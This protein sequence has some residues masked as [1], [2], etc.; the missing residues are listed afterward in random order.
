MASSVTNNFAHAS[1]LGN[2]RLS[3]VELTVR[4]SK[5]GKRILAGQYGLGDTIGE[6]QLGKIRLGWRLPPQEQKSPS[7]YENRIVL[8]THVTPEPNTKVAVKIFNISKLRKMRNLHAVRAEIDCLSRLS[9]TNIIKLYEIIENPSKHR[10]YLVIELLEG[11]LNELIGTNPNGL[12]EEE[13][14]PLFYR[15]FSAV[16]HCHQNQVA[17]RDIKPDNVMFTSDGQVRLMDFSGGELD[18][19]SAPSISSAI[20]LLQQSTE[21]PSLLSEMCYWGSPAFLP[22]E[23]VDTVSPL[24]SSLQQGFSADSWAL[25][26]SLHITLTGRFPFPSTDHCLA[27]VQDDIRHGRLKIFYPAYSLWKPTTRTTPKTALQSECFQYSKVSAKPHFLKRI[28]FGI[29]KLLFSSDNEPDES[30]LATLVPPKED[31]LSTHF[32]SDSP[33]WVSYSMS[34]SRPTSRASSRAKSRPRKFD[35]QDAWVIDVIQDDTPSLSEL[36]ELTN[37]NHPIPPL[38]GSL[39]EFSEEDFKKD[40]V[41][42]PCSVL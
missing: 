18:P 2:F 34:S 1:Q 42:L 7:K 14:L 10:I 39:S 32:Y 13:A 26:I 30:S 22:P 25:G 33:D 27:N 6:G 38:T 17:H 5:P 35:P 28:S 23:L 19:S 4:S 11:T 9:H 8:R 20:L 37:G 40:P 24:Q 21:D 36:A 12:S 3:S 29:K 15:V 16:S 31:L 41:G